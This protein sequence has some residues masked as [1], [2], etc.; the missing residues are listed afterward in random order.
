M[1]YTQEQLDAVRRYSEADALLEE[2]VD[3]ELLAGL[4][5]DDVGVT[6]ARAEVRALTKI[7]D[8]AYD[9]VVALGMDDPEDEYC[10]DIDAARAILYG[11]PKLIEYR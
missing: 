10:D 5:R 9:Q 2:A 6:A 1:A 8:E 7:Y 4:E 11:P 3:R